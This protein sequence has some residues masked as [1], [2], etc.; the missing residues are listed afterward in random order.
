MMAVTLKV[1][2]M[3]V[4]DYKLGCF[5]Q[6]EDTARCG[7]CPDKGTCLCETKWEADQKKTDKKKK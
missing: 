6:W 3:K 5:G 1:M 4:M 2:R 7:M